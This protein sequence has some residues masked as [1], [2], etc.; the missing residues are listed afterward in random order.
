MAEP[1]RSARLPRRPNVLIVDDTPANLVALEAVLGDDYGVVRA[2]SGAQAISIL[3]AGQGIDVILMDVQ[4][5]RMDGFE[6]AAQIKKLKGCH[7]IPIIFVTAVYK[8]DPYVKKGYQAGGI[9]YFSK[10]FD[11]DILRMKIGIYAAHRL[12]VE[13][14]EQRERHL[15]ESEEL[16]RVGCKLSSMLEELPVGV[17]IADL[18]GRVCQTTEGASRVLSSPAAGDGGHAVILGWWDQSGRM[19]E[20]GDGPLARALQRGEPSHMSIEIPCPGGESK[21]VLVSAAPLLGLDAKIAGAVVLVQDF[22]RARKMEEDIEQKVTKLIALGAEP[23]VS[24]GP[25]PK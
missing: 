14:L 6:A 1:M 7:D 19:V 3:Q 11:P 18:D 9:D 4:M 24:S 25:N 21:A 15:R 13:I 20:H 10:P 16:L 2:S 8:E 17:L 12:N 22:T 23:E 5:P